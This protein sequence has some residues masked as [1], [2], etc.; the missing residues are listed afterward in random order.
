ML[1]QY[2]YC[3]DHVWNRGKRQEEQ[4]KSSERFRLKDGE[5][6]ENGR[7]LDS[8]RNAHDS[9]RHTRCTCQ[10]TPFL[11]AAKESML[12]HDT[13]N[14]GAIASATRDARFGRF[15]PG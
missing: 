7:Y 8:G 10:P 13:G 14:F 5:G 12:P 9:H 15:A 2:L 1:L 6:S 3:P 4:R 11:T